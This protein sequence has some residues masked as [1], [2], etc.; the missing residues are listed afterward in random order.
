MMGAVISSGNG[1]AGIFNADIPEIHSE[2]A[3]SKNF[4]VVSNGFDNLIPFILLSIKLLKYK[5]PVTYVTG[6]S[7]FVSES[8]IRSV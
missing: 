4:S 8:N 5:N 2:T 7:V 6:L 1:S 3:F